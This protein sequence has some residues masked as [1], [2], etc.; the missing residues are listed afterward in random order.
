PHSN[1]CTRAS[2][3]PSSTTHRSSAG[4]HKKN[5]RTTPQPKQAS[6]P[7]HD[8]PPSKPQNVTSASTPSHHPSPCTPSWS[9]SPPTSSSKNSPTKKRSAATQSLGKSPTP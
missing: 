3:E 1:T 9:K 7:S 8:A 2:K 6:W 4:A 5:K